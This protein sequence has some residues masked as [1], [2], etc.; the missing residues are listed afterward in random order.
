MRFSYLVLFIVVLTASCSSTTR[1]YKGVYEASEKITE[2]DIPPDLDK[3]INNEDQTLRELGRS[4]T[5]YSIYEQNLKGQPTS[6]RFNPQYRDMSFRRDGRLFWLDVK[7]KPE[8]VWDDVR[9]FFRKLGF[10]FKVDRPE[11]GFLQTDWRENRVDIPGNWVGKLLGALYSAE[12]MDRYRIRVEWDAQEEVSR[13]FINHQGLREVVEGEDDN[14]SIVTTRW[15]IRPSDPDLEVEMIMRLM[16]YRGLEEKLAEEQ[17]ATTGQKEKTVIQQSGD[18]VQL[19]MDEPY[20]RAWRLVTI[21]IDRLGYLVEDKNRSAGVFYVQ[22]PETFMVKSTSGIFSKLFS[23]TVKPEH[24]KYL[25][26]LEEKNAQTQVT[27][28]SNGDEKEDFPKVSQKI[29]KD[30]KDSIL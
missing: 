29:L 12:I 15:V 27:V 3:P 22:L 4:I 16:A 23:G 28:K 30:I 10:E 19:V 7:A 25:I 17:I 26:I 14:V 2:L 20:P 11:V 13:V 8:Q 18:N 1:D 6:S 24:D 5:T 21:A 9:G